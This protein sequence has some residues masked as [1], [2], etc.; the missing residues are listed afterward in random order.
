MKNLIFVFLILVA[1][2][3]EKTAPTYTSIAGEWRIGGDVSGQFTL[4]QSGDDFLVEA[5]SYTYD[6]VKYEVNTKRIVE[7]GPNFEISIY[8]LSD[9][10]NA[11]V[12][13]SC[14]YDMVKFNLMSPDHVDCYSSSGFETYSNV[15]VTR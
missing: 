12:L 6:G 10:V 15:T 11:C 1:C 9:N 7:N 5:G 8:L 2:S 13:R 4:T 3:E 14:D